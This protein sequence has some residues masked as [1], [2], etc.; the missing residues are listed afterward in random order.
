MHTHFVG[1][2]EEDSPDNGQI[3]DYAHVGTSSSNS[4]V[5]LD[6]NVTLDVVPHPFE[7]A[8]IETFFNGYLGFVVA[9]NVI[10][11]FMIVMNLFLV[12]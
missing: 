11:D 12:I 3:F 5:V 6:F 9:I 10:H 7:V 8:R 1:L 2:T 4:R